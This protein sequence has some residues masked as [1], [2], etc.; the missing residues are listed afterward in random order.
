MYKTITI[1]YIVCFFCYILFTRQPD[2]F[3]GEF[4]PAVIHLVKDSASQKIVATASFSVGKDHYTVDA[5]Y[6]LRHLEEG[7]R[8]EVIYELS[9]PPKAA[10][11]SWWGYWISAGELIASI[12]LYIIL[13][14]VAISINRNPTPEALME[15][16]NY[17]PE[18]KRKY[19]S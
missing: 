14:Q 12:V 8:V 4:A 11:Y 17:K 13:F 16:L 19:T 2:Y 5:M 3:D 15:Q 7:D 18:K 6:P 1:L 9:Q 10:V